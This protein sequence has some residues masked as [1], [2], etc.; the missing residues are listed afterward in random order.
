MAPHLIANG[1]I[2]DVVMPQYNEEVVG[3]LS[4]ARIIETG[5]VPVKNFLLSVIY[6][7]KRAKKTLGEEEIDVVHAATP[8]RGPFGLAFLGGSVIDAA[9]KLNL[10]VVAG[11]QTFNKDVAR[12]ITPHFLRHIGKPITDRFVERQE[13]RMHGRA[14]VNYSVSMA[15][16]AY[17]M[18]RDVPAHK[19]VRLKNGIHPMFDPERRDSPEATRQRRD[20]GVKDDELLVLVVGRLAEEKSLHRLQDIADIT[21]TR[22]VVVGDG[23]ERKKLEKLLPDAIF[24]GAVAHGETLANMYAC[25]DIKALT[26][27]TESYSQVLFE[28]M[29]SGLPVV[30]PNE[31]AF[32]EYIE[33]GASGYTY[34]TRDEFRNAIMKLAASPELRSRMGER[35]RALTEGQTWEEETRKLETIY[36]LAIYLNKQPLA[37]RQMNRELLTSSL[38]L[39]QARPQVAL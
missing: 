17:L 26:S 4:G 3:D 15:M 35:G 28:A 10:P 8:M 19:I 11:A 31:R 13:R 5:A 23:T 32:R 30:A 38:G 27:A 18:E 12:N 20:L 9:N 22:T 6:T 33:N 34:E 29:A 25:A 14:D 39:E 36:R 7:A 24:T 2:L 37:K 16:D 21:G 1:H